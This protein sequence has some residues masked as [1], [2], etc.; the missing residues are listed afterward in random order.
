MGRGGSGPAPQQS[1]DRMG[2]ETPELITGDRR[3]RIF[4]QLQKDRTVL[5][6]RLLGRDYERLTMVIGV[7]Q[8]GG[9]P[10]FLIDYPRGFREAVSGIPVWM[11]RF[12]FIGTDH[13][14]YRF[15]TK[16]G[17]ILKDG[18]HLPLPGAIER[19]QRRAHFRVEAPLGST[20]RF[21]DPGPGG[22]LLEMALVNVSVG[23]A[24]MASRKAGG[25]SDSLGMDTE[26]RD[27]KLF[28]PLPDED[29]TIPVRS[30]VVK[31]VESDGETG[32]P[33]YAVRFEPLPA[34]EADRLNELI[35]EI[36]RIQLRRQQLL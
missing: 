27:L 28:F 22:D 32:K 9:Q 3:T 34:A 11:L 18:V 2:M 15:R 21:P 13:L 5:T 24:L 16:G 31:R 36:Q 26:I 19:I 30:A 29:V 1:F 23:G 17:R 33:K 14:A 7:E 20:V 12:E 35:W 6:L 25:P 4:R 10:S 8:D